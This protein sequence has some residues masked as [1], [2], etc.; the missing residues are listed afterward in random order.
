MYL[1][2]NSKIETNNTNTSA[3]I[4]VVDDIN[5]QNSFE[6][7]ATTVV[8]INNPATT[9]TIT[10]TFTPNVDSCLFLNLNNY[11]NLSS[12]TY[13]KF[14]E[15]IVLEGDF[16]EQDINY[17]EGKHEVKSISL[18]QPLHKVGNVCDR[19]YW[20]ETRGKM[21]IEKNVAEIDFSNFD[22]SPCPYI[23]GRFQITVPNMITGEGSLICN[24]IKAYGTNHGDLH[25]DTTDS[26]GYIVGA[27]DSNKQ[28]ILRLGKGMTKNDT[29]QWLINH[30]T[31]IYHRISPEII[32]TL[33]TMYQEF[34]NYFE[35]INSLI[36]F[37]PNEKGENNNV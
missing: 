5:K 7:N 14:S 11:S 37:I 2:I 36:T 6:G 29:I 20:D 8:S 19:F 15:I 25:G 1:N 31:K 24:S 3:R 32:E 27:I 34:V 23:S 28:I 4:I 22:F 10:T 17:Y 13:M 9:K 33:S 26:N 12:E 18:P 21:C 16:N 30:N 35:R